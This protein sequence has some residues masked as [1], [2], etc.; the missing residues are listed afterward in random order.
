MGI[1]DRLSNFFNNLFEE[2]SV[3]VPRG[4]SFEKKELARKIEQLK[5]DISKLD[6]FHGCGIPRLDHMS[7]Y[8]IERS[9]FEQL[10]RWYES[11]SQN[12][13]SLERKKQILTQGTNKVSENLAHARWSG[14][15]TAGM[16]D[17]DLDWSQR[18]D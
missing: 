8:E 2:E 7:I 3:A 13:E 18:G 15:K 6:S 10:E 5:R 1:I 14:Q 9:S 12:L 17:H 4:D 16:T 11:L